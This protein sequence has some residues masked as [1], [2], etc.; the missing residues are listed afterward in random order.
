MAL[1]TE[2]ST[3]V[4]SG[5]IDLGRE[6][7]DLTLVPKTRATSPVALRSPIHVKGSFS[8]PDIQLDTASV[9]ARSIGAVALGLI[10][11][12]LAL[13]PLVELGPGVESHCK[14]MIRSVKITLSSD[15]EASSSTAAK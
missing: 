15:S 5:R 3:I 11:P 13:I 8:S 2:V 7:L 12:L 9:A 14:A 10:N 6:T 4:G 1:E